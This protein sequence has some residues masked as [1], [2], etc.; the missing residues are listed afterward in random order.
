MPNSFDT[1][2]PI[3]PASTGPSGPPTSTVW[4]TFV[5]P[6]AA[7]SMRQLNRNFVPGTTLVTSAKLRPACTSTSCILW[8]CPAFVFMTP[9]DPETKPPDQS[10]VSTFG[11]HSPHV[12]MSDQIRQTFS[13]AALVSTDVPYS[14]AIPSSPQIPHAV[15][16]AP[17]RRSRGS[18][19]TSRAFKKFSVTTPV[20][21]STAPSSSMGRR[22]AA[23]PTG[24]GREKIRNS[25]SG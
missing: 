2:G 23:W 13:G 18:S 5:F 12:D 14:R 25:A 6:P 19:T 3:I 1:C 15:R 10:I 9:V 24:A 20:T 16:V 4:P 11:F 7:G 17:A 21:R 22:G 8:C